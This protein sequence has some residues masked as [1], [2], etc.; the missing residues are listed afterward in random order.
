MHQPRTQALS[1]RGEHCWR[2]SI[3]AVC[4]L[5]FGFRA[6]DR[7]VGCRIDDHRRFDR[8]NRVR[9]AIK[10]GQVAAQAPRILARIT[11]QRDHLAQWREAALQLPPHLSITS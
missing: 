1:L 4:E 11:P 5:G 7:R 8:A 2:Q 3:Q 6:V 10:L 9:Q